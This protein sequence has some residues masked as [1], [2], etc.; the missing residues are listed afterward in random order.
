MSKG[1]LMFQV[2]G[3]VDWNFCKQSMSD[4]TGNYVFEVFG[5]ILCTKL[6]LGISTRRNVSHVLIY[7][8]HFIIVLNFWNRQ[9]WSFVNRLES[10]MCHGVKF[11]KTEAL[12]YYTAQDCIHKWRSS[13][14]MSTWS[15]RQKVSLRW[16]LGR[17]I[18]SMISGWNGSRNYLIFCLHINSSTDLVLLS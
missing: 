5:H 3:D 7:V 17:L 2:C 11:L 18:V 1:Y 10:L 6:A 12:I 14:V 9:T 4:C 16:I 15:F 13:W 8:L